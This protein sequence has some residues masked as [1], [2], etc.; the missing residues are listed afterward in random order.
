MQA[1]ALNLVRFLFSL[2]TSGEKISPL[3]PSNTSQEPKVQGQEYK[4]HMLFFGNNGEQ[5]KFNFSNLV[6]RPIY[7]T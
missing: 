4:S 2:L 5:E 1:E 3:R 6:F 7:G